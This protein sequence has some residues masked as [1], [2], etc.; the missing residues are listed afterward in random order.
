MKIHHENEIKKD[1]KKKALTLLS[2]VPSILLDI[3]IP[4]RRIWKNKTIIGLYDRNSKIIKSLKKLV[5]K[6]LGFN[7]LPYW[8]FW[9]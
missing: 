5:A 8:I 7:V 1:K 2:N 6:I 3:F 9:I 4:T